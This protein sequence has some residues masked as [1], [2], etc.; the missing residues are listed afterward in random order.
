VNFA[1]SKL[2]SRLMPR[3]PILLIKLIVPFF[4]LIDIN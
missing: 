2:A 1:Y 4:Y 3:L